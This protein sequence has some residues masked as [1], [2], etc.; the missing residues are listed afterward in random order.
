MSTLVSTLLYPVHLAVLTSLHAVLASARLGR[1]ILRLVQLVPSPSPRRRVKPAPAS[2]LEAARWRKL[3]RHLAV[4][5]VPGRGGWDGQDALRIKVDGVERL[6]G[7]CTELGVRTLSVYDETGLLVRHAA[8]VA[9]ELELAVVGTQEDIEMEGMATLGAQI[10]SKDVEPGAPD[11]GGAP[12]HAAAVVV[13][14]DLAQDD[15]SSFT[16]VDTAS[17]PRPSSPIPSAAP[18]T[19]TLHLLSRAA[20]RPRL[21]R[22]AARLAA[23]GTG[24]TG[25][26]G[27]KGELTAEEVAGA[28]DALPLGEPDLLLVLGG[29]YLRLLGF[30]PWQLRLTELHHHSHPTWLPAVEVQYAHLRAALDTYGRAEMRLGR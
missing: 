1:L 21:A 5:L 26:E 4:A 16:L 29:S 6:L 11:P 9:Q 14:P 17:P 8:R 18:S 24:G 28:I 2:D 25:G 3:P 20:G 12:P 10:A 27:K 13:L 22:L 7:W 30:P 19:P 23:S 15:A